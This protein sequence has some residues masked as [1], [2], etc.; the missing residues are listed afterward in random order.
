MKTR[1]ITFEGCEGVGKSTQIRLLKE[2]LEKTGQPA[3]F[4]REPGGTPVAEKVR[5]ILLSPDHAL[6]P[7]VEAYLFAAAR[8]DHVAN[9]IRPAVARGELVICDRFLDS[10]LAYQGEARELGMEEVF[11]L[12]GPAIGDCTPDCTVFLDLSPENNWRRKK[13]KVVENDR[14][15]AES[16]EFHLAVYRG[17]KRLAANSP[18]V[19]SVVPQEDKMETHRLIVEALRERGLIR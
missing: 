13:G 7:L 5:E 6:S 3:L 18:K 1:F 14:M 8:A 15:E 11:W 16:L 2:Y 17:F 9:V 19:V 4:T 12:N 10:S